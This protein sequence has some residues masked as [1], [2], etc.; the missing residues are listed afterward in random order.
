MTINSS[1]MDRKILISIFFILLSFFGLFS[2]KAEA[3]SVEDSPLT[4]DEKQYLINILKF[5][6]VEVDNLPA[7]LSL[8]VRNLLL[9]QPQAK[10][11]SFI[12][13]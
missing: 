10:Y 12:V 1:M 13:L 9:S 5:S 3:S 2:L 4:E 6:E 7:F 8:L 11:Y